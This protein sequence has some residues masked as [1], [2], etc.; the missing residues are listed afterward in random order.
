MS[1]ETLTRLAIGAVA[2]ALGALSMEPPSGVLF[3]TI[4]P[5]GYVRWVCP[6]PDETNCKKIGLD[7]PERDLKP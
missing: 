1:N 4:H 7:G 2:F 3:N 5:D 6:H